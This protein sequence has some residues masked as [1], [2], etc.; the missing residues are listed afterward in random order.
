MAEILDILAQRIVM[1]DG[2][3]LSARARR[4]A[5]GAA[6]PV[7]IEIIPYRKHDGT[8]ARDEALHPCMAAR[9]YASLR[10]DLRGSGDSA[11]ILADE[12][13]PQGLAA[14]CTAIALAAGQ[15][16]VRWRVRDDGQKL[17]RVQ[18]TSGSR[19]ATPR[20]TGGDCGLRH[21]RP[22]CR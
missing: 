13:T 14:A 8:A 6:V 15:A 16:L 11:G 9:G 20:A 2:M 7:I 22:L 18:R 3:F 19:L 12:Y 17:G 21:E 1:P 5:T 4:P 10:V